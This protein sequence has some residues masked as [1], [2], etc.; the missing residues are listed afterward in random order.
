MHKNGKTP[1]IFLTLALLA[2]LAL[3]GC[4]TP[5]PVPPTATEK[6]TPSSTPLP[7]PTDTPAPPTT[8]PSDGLL[9]GLRS[10]SYGPK[11]PFP[12]PDYWVSTSKA[13]S[14]LF[15]ASTPSIVWIVGEIQYQDSAGIAGLNFP[16][17]DGKKAEDYP[18]VIFSDTD[19]NEEYFDQ[20]DQNGIKVWLQVEPGDTDVLTL[21]DLIMSRYSSHPCVIG[22]GV[23][24]EW[25]KWNENSA[26]EGTA[27]T[28]AEAQAWS[29]KV[30]SYNPD[31][32][33]FT[34]HWL[35]EKMPPTYRTG[36]FFLDDSQQ[37]SDLDSMVEEFI[38]WGE[39]FAPAP[40]GFQYG[41]EDD[42]VWWGKLENLPH[43]I[44]QALL[45]RIPNTRGLYWVDFTMEQI[46][47][48]TK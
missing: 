15:P 25:Y 48:R 17:P 23:D 46:W 28:D 38:A 8:A 27:V 39:A 5:A 12:G 4:A 32:L 43:D 22:F 29:E 2:S 18:D 26:P 41:Y 30:R 36:M 19:K 24:V 31:Y 21:I 44:G 3:P 37:F 7:A 20:F 6:I 13:M 1:F 40:V 47:P 10:S 35:V 45:D 16:V 9:A 33:L 34:K 42:E 11:E 14:D